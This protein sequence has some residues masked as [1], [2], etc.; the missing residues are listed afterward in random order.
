MII[1]FATSKVDHKDWQTHIAGILVTIGENSGAGM[2]KLR[3]RVQEVA[4]ERGFTMTKLSHRSE[5][6]F[7]TVSSLFKD[8]YRTVNTHTLFRLSQTMG[9]SIHDLLEEV[10]DDY[11]ES[12]G[13]PE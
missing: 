9:V 3:L 12:T 2:T 6:S 13:S 11:E 1:K 5:I 8:P 4:T 10:P 7:N